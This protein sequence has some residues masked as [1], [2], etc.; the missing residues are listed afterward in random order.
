MAFLDTKHKKKSFTL[1]TVLLALLILLMF[2]VGL[3]YMDPP[4]ESGISVNFGTTDYGKGPTQPLRKIKTAPQ[5]KQE[6]Q[7]KEEIQKPTPQE[8]Q[9]NVEEVLANENSDAP[10]IPPKKE[11]VKE[12]SQKKPEPKKEIPKKVEKPTPSKATTDALSSILNGPENDGAAKGSEG[13][14]NKAGDKGQPDGDPYA[15]SYYGAPGSGN[16]NGV[17]YG[18]NGRK[19]VST[20]KVQQDCN[21]SGTVVVKIEVDRSGNVISAVPGVRGTTNNSPCLLKPA[22]ETALK[23]RWNLDSNAPSRQIGFIVVNFKLG[24]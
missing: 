14:D 19:L 23:Y 2:Y 6:E 3:S 8:P 5:P 10:V 4:D 12:T 9:K 21:E 1:T 20:G 18:L 11:K 15:S 13:D 16:G 7:P 24:E 22:K 17:G